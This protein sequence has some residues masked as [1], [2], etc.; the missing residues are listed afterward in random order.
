[1]TILAVLFQS[2]VCIFDMDAVYGTIL[3]FPNNDECDVL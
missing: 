3:N 2:A 1:M